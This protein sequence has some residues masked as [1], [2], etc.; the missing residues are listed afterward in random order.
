MLGN[1]LTTST[2]GVLVDLV[3]DLGRGV[4]EEDGGVRVA[5]GHLGLGSLEGGEEGGVDESRFEEAQTRSDVSGHPEVWILIN[6][7]GNEAGNVWFATED[8]GKC[9]GEGGSCLNGGETNFTDGATFIKPKNSY[10]KRNFFLIS[11]N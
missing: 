3:L 5:G 7:T 8:E 2:E 9:G 10:R 6:G 11:N 4:R 1:V